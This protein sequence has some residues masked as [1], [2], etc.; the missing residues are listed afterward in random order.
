MS[1]CSTL[2]AVAQD[3]L[4]A[5]TLSPGHA[6]ALL[7]LEEDNAIA[8]ALEHVLQEGLNV[9]QTETLVKELLAQPDP[10]QDSDDTAAELLSESLA[11][12]NRIE[13]K[14][15]SVLGTR[16]NLNRNDDGSGRLVV[17]FYN[18]AD[19]EQIFRQIAG[20]DD[21]T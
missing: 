15:R 19:L 17:H 7:A 13:D 11:E 21:E 16:V 14:L 1:A 20:G 18:D 4:A 6:R 2:P 8:T 9:R 3:A 5:G 12:L 10:S